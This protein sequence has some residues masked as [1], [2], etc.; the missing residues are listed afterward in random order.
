VYVLTRESLREDSALTKVAFSRL[1]EWLDDGV[2]SNGERYVEIRRRLVQ[3]FDRRNRPRPDDLAD[4]TLN[5]IA[6]TLEESTVIA[7]RPPARYCYVVAKFVLF[8]DVRRERRRVA[9]DE[10]HIGMTSP[11]AWREPDL[12]D[13]RLDCLERCLR[14]LNPEQRELIVEYYAD[15]R[16]RKIERRRALA[17]RLGI[18]MNALGIRAWRIRESLMASVEACRRRRRPI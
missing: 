6:R 11:V 16:R 8:E 13:E 2:D 14:Q 7:T 15:T 12:N 9:F 10:A 18:S 17:E 3:Y 4:E 1:L 5:R